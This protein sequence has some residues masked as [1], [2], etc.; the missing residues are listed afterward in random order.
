M[1]QMTSASVNDLPDSAFAYIEPGGTK[2]SDGRT[3]PRSKRHFPVH[4]EAHARNALARLSSSPFGPK[5]KAKVMA[6]A[7]KF[8]IH[9]SDD[10][11]HSLTQADEVRELRITSLYKDLH[12]PLE[13]RDID[14]SG[15]WIGGYATVFMPRMSTNLGGF[16][17][18][19]APHAFDEARMG[20]W[21]DVVC[22]FNHDSNLVLG[23]TAANTL[24]LKTDRMGLDYSVLTPESRADVRELV[25][26]GD[27]RYSSF[28]FRVLPGG[29]EW[30]VTDQ[31][32][33][34]RTL[35]SLELADVAPVLS[36]GYPDATAA[37][38]ATKGALRS[39]A[40]HFQM[41]ADE[42][43]SLADNDE[44]RK[45]FIRSDRPSS[46]PIKRAEPP[47]LF[48]PLA[49]SLLLRREKDPYDDE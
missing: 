9:V 7:R 44:L 19:V 20:G 18:Q 22:R 34:L 38:R 45:L 41:S 36:P 48:G 26:R 8:G 39:L 14:S 13:V 10:A 4:D 43:R 46:K 23:T 5:A 17:E 42:I 47:K 1:A 21:C 33:P 11:G 28:A 6:A 31:N 3:M 49:A 12:N 27:I 25:Q 15:R 37:I 29:D 24:Q 32:F 30:S 2:D 16:V 35:H 40:D